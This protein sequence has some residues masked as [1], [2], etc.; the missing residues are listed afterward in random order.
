VDLGVHH[1]VVLSTGELFENPRPISRHARRM[2]RL[3][4]ELSRAQKGSRRRAKTGAKLARCHARVADLRRDSLHKLTT[5]LATA[6]G[7][8]VIEDLVVKNMTVSP[9]AK[10]DPENPGHHLLDG[11]AAKAGL[12]RSILDLA[13]PRH[14]TEQV[15]QGLLDRPEPVSPGSRFL[16]PPAPAASEQLAADLPVLLSE[17]EASLVRAP[18]S[19]RAQ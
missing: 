15:C 1:L 14:T 17:G 7:T 4:R 12:N 6:Y 19:C 10:A 3:N 5:H 2:A 18:T 8:V 9:K 11:H 16:S 13:A